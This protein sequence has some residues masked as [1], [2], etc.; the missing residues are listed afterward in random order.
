MI[1]YRRLARVMNL[2]PA[3]FLFLMSVGMAVGVLR[4]WHELFQFNQ[5]N[6]ILPWIGVIWSAL[7][8]FFFIAGCCVTRKAMEPD[9]LRRLDLIS[10]PPRDGATDPNSR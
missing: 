7:A 8:I 3:G 4:D 6:R 9:G 5:A 2:A 10:Q 1:K